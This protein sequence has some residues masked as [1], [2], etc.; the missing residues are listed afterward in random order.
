MAFT[1]GGITLDFPPTPDH[2]R[3]A[4]RIVKGREATSLSGKP[5]S[6]GV[7]RKKTWT[8]TFY[9]GAQYADIIA[10]VGTETTFTDHDGNSYTVAVMGEPE[11]SQ[12]PIDSIGLITLTLREV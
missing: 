10:L 12:Y 8:L 2:Y 3:V 9:P 6:L 5:L 1:L 11:V 4:Y 7:V